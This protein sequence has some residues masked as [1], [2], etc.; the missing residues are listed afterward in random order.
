MR[1]WGLEQTDVF[2]EKLT[3]SIDRLYTSLRNAVE[4]QHGGADLIRQ[5]IRSGNGE[6]VSLGLFLL[7]DFQRGLLQPDLEDTLN[8]QH[9]P[10]SL[11][12]LAYSM[13]YPE[14][15]REI[16]EARRHDVARG[17]RRSRGSVRGGPGGSPP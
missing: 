8:N 17:R 5:L 6:R 4:T 3:D 2:R 13:L 14:R 9:L 16:V 12:R 11:R 7:P 1:R 10:M 15:Q